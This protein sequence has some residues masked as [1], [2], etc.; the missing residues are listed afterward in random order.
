MPNTRN[1]ERCL[2]FAKGVGAVLAAIIVSPYLLT[3]AHFSKNR[4]RRKA[5]AMFLDFF[6]KDDAP[7][8][9]WRRVKRSFNVY[10]WCVVAN[11]LNA[12]TFILKQ[13]TTRRS[14]RGKRLTSFRRSFRVSSS[15]CRSSTP[16]LMSWALSRR[17]VIPITT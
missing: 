5:I 14:T 17:K 1:E 15:T 6:E 7:K 4:I 16:S 2:K 12:T 13:R 8:P 9:L 3:W 11:C 10:G